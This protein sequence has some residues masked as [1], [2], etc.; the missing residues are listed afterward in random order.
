M[1][2]PDRLI[3]LKRPILV[4]VKDPINPGRMLN[5]KMLAMKVLKEPLTYVK[6]AP[7]TTYA[8]VD[9]AWAADT[10]YEGW[11]AAEVTEPLFY[12]DMAPANIEGVQ[13]L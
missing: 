2:A 10:W 8:V 11:Y 7:T 1:E 4:Q 12:I 6:D 3:T 5:H 9:Y 13:W